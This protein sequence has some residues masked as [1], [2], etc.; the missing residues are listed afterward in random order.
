MLDSQ[1]F[2]VGEGQLDPEVL[3]VLELAARIPMPAPDHDAVRDAFLEN[4]FSHMIAGWMTTNVRRESDGL[5]WR[6]ELEGVRALLESYASTDL[7]NVIENAASPVYVVR[8]G[9]STRWDPERVRTLTE[10]LV[11]RGGEMVVLEKAGHWV[12]VD[13]PEGTLTLL[14]KSLGT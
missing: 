8:A 14:G 9:K 5:R 11:R 2:A 3:G 10:A 4:G 6:F 1:P 12:H 13:D 7:M